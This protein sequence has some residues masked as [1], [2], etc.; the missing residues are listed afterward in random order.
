MDYMGRPAYQT[1]A[2]DQN[3]NKDNSDREQA[4]TMGMKGKANEN[5]GMPRRKG[6]RWVPS[7]L[8]SYLHPTTVRY[9][10]N[11]EVDSTAHGEADAEGVP[12]VVI[13]PG[14]LIPICGHSPCMLDVTQMADENGLNLD[15]DLICGLLLCCFRLEKF[16]YA[17]HD[18]A[19][20]EVAVS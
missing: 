12:A 8:S 14:A 5:V 18:F 1:V 7:T 19:D 9:I 4:E 11:S 3:V 20:E 6:M 16:A 10:L 2:D 13:G 15:L 17:G